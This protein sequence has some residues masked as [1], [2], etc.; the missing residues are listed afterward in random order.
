MSLVIIHICVLVV[1]VVR[2]NEVTFFFSFLS[3]CACVL[4]FVPEF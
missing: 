1:T 2:F 3:V 4:R